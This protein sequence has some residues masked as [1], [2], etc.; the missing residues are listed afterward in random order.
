M[1]LIVFRIL[2]YLKFLYRSGNAHG[3][4]SPFVYSLYTTGLNQKINNSDF[5]E[6]ENLRASFLNDP[7][8]IEVKDF[9]AGSQKMKSSK[10]AIRSIAK[11]SV[12]G[13]HKCLILYKLVQHLKPHNILELGTSLG[14]ST[15]YLSS[16]HP[17]SKIIS[18]EA[19][20]NL[21]ELASEHLKD[22][23]EV[24]N[25]TFQQALSMQAVL[26]LNPDFIFI[27]GD[28]R[29]ESLINYVD[30]ILEFASEECCIVIDDIYW[31]EDMNRGWNKLKNDERFGISIDLF[32]FG[33]LFTRSKQPKQHFDL[34]V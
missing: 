26:N 6:I 5:V 23:V 27:D 19:D 33:L 8:E 29:G 25:N 14:I 15:Q 1:N 4:H 30:S 12:S 11:N 20:K 31:S 22:K 21:A 17:G 24:I 16:G 18:I 2:S 32:H 7:R 34:R 28:H 13:H 3:L 10:R 9:G